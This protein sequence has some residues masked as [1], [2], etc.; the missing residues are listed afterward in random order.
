MAIIERG[1]TVLHRGREAPELLEEETAELAEKLQR[2]IP[3]PAEREQ[4]IAE[5]AY[6]RAQGRHF[7]P[8]QELEDWLEAE[9]ELEAKLDRS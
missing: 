7:A 1:K 4:M 9:A 5:A 6:F 2:R 3:T 8:G